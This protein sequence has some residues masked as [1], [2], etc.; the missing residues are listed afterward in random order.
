MKI[1]QLLLLLSLVFGH[2]VVSAID[3]LDA[4]NLV[5]QTQTDV[6]LDGNGV[7][8]SPDDSIAVVAQANGNLDAYD[9]FTGQKLWK[10][11]PPSNNNL[12]LACQGGVTFSSD[13]PTDYL[14]YS[15]VD[16]PNGVTSYT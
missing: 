7:F 13:G 11:V 12:P 10:F 4:P 8:I 15:V 2:G 3:H 9:T 5:W 1:S 6:I 14:I 16:D